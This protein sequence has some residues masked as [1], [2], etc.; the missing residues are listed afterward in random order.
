MP[1]QRLEKPMHMVRHH[2]QVSN[3]PPITV[4]VEQRANN[5]FPDFRLPEK[6]CTVAL[7]YFDMQP[8][9][10]APFERLTRLLGQAVV[11]RMPFWV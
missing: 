1:G 3:P 11:R 7:V 10:R 9:G 8:T 5:G 2:D 4:V 6:A